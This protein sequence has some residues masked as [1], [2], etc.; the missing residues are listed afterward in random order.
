MVLPFSEA[1]SAGTRVSGIA[2]GSAA[3]E[4][5][6]MLRSDSESEGWIDFVDV[7]A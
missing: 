3:E 4:K 5:G 1:V 6:R 7:E 2:P